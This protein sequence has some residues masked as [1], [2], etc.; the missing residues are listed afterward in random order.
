MKKIL[1]HKIGGLFFPKKIKQN[2]EAYVKYDRADSLAFIAV[3]I[4]FAKVLAFFISNSKLKLKKNQAKANG[5]NLYEI[6]KKA[7]ILWHTPNKNEQ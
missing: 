3:F 6:H 1:Y 4:F 2:W 7:P 5:L